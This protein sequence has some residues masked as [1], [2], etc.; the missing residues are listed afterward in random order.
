LAKSDTSRG[1]HRQAAIVA[2]D[3]DAH[4]RNPAAALN[5]IFRKFAVER[6]PRSNAGGR[7]PAKKLPVVLA[8]IVG[9]RARLRRRGKI[10]VLG[11]TGALGFAI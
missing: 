2:H 3:G 4:E 6:Q 10:C 7:A 11:F 5:E 8:A 9:R 1:P